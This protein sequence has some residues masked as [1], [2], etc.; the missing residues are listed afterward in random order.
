MLLASCDIEEKPYGF[1]SDDN[2]YQTVDDADAALMYAYNALTFLEYSRGIFYIGECASET[3]DLKSGEDA[4][5]PGA[6]ALDEWKISDNANN[7]TLQLYFKYCY[8]AINRANAVISN[9]EKSTAID[10]A[11]KQRLLGEAY[12]L[13]GYNYFNLVKVFGLVPIQRQMVQTVDQTSPAM[14]A[15]MDE[16]YDFMHKVLQHHKRT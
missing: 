3:V 15:D 1:Y 6:Q 10:T 7:Q 4:N 13:R 8:I 14:A 5:N 9:V 16:M 11:D 12:F 2:F